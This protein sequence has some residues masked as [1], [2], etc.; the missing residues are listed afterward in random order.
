MTSV[1][2]AVKLLLSK[3]EYHARLAR[4][5]AEAADK[6]E[7]AMRAERGESVQQTLLPNQPAN[8]QGDRHDMPAI[9]PK[10]LP[11]VHVIRRLLDQKSM[12]QADLADYFGVDA[13][14]LDDLLT[15]DNGFTKNERGWLKYET[16]ERE[17]SAK[18]F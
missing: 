2:E 7:A 9:Q 15:K 17:A 3:A 6:A 13:A 4:H 14:A 5:F 18:P 8:G 16:L 1:A 11:S 10:P 12:R